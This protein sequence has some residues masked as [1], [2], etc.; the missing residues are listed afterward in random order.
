MASS[1]V[2]ANN[3]HESNYR[4]EDVELQAGKLVPHPRE[5][6]RNVNDAHMRRYGRPGQES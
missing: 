1:L 4:Y 5:F 3:M 2:S 6:P